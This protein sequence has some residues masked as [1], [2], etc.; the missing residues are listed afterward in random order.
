MSG[1]PKKPTDV[2]PEAGATIALIVERSRREYAAGGA[3][4]VGID[5]AIMGRHGLKAGA[6]VR[7]ATFMR[8]ILARVDAPS[9]EDH[10][11]G[12]VRLDRFQRQALQARLYSTVEVTP[13]PERAVGSV[14]LQPAVDLAAAGEH[15]LEEHL[16]EELVHSRAPVAEGALLFLHFQHSVAGTLYKVV[17]VEGESG[18]VTHATD[19]LLDPA[20]AGFSGALDLDVTFEDV[21]GL[22]REIA[23]VKELVQIPLQFPSVYR[24][25]G[26]APVR[27]II[28]HGPPGTG[29]TLLARAMANEVDG[30]FYYINGPEIVGT[31]YGES[32]AN[33]RRIFGEAVHHAP[34]MVFIDELDVLALKRGESGA[35]ADTRLVTQLLALM[36]GLSKVDGVV[37]VGTTNRIE[38]MD[39]AVRRPGRFDRELYIRPPDAHGRAQIL[40]IHTREMPLADGA[41]A[42]L[43]ELAADTPGFVGADL[44][45]LCREAGLQAL[46]RHLPATRTPAQWNP[47]ELR[48]E[49]EDFTAARSL[50][51]PS[52]GRVSLVATPEHGYERVGGLAPAKAQLRRLLA[53]PLSKAV[54][55]YAGVVLVGPPGSGK[56]LLA[57]ATAKEAGVNLVAVSG[58]ELFSQWLGQS[59]QA[60]RH[61]FKLARELAP[62]LVFFDQLD[63]LA[64]VRGISSGGWTTERVVH[65][66]IAEL[67]GLDSAPIAVL[68]ATN[69]LDLVD[70][71]LLQPGRLGVCLQIAPP[72]LKERG[73]ILALYLDADAKTRQQLARRTAGWSGGEL[74]GL[75][76]FLKQGLAKPKAVTWDKLFHQWVQMRPR[77]KPVSK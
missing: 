2:A 18:V 24:Q 8:E 11:A 17:K 33:L 67:D 68:A 30:Q 59:E 51:Q 47:E 55:A 7:I 38:A 40:Q 72:A 65:Q 53:E 61:V 66:L 52:A 50:L 41:R 75:A 70:P 22:D 57:R 23:V 73:E 31:T 77:A 27:G 14:R 60:L 3:S 44:M 26:I 32:E 28:L 62:C 25:L 35:H 64:P 69:R 12:I 48:V 15:R 46:R 58:P 45:A 42:C 19:V 5:P 56:S 16:K 76:E 43:A 9:E 71:A 21:G 37:V 63:A 54:R 1:I 13:E 4:L 34:S 49:R 20:P 10:G 36:D 39:M 29:K 6:L 74:R